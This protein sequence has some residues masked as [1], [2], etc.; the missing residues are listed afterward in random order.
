MYVYV[1]F[2]SFSFDFNLA[3]GFLHKFIVYLKFE[4][5]YFYFKKSK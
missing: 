3:K 4:G 2:F 5:L 1:F